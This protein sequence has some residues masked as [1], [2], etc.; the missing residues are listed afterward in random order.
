[1]GSRTSPLDIHAVLYNMPIHHLHTLL[2]LEMSL[3]ALSEVG[4]KILCSNLTP[5]SEVGAKFSCSNLT[6]LSEVG[7]KILCSNLTQMPIVSFL[8][9]EL[10][11]NPA[12]TLVPW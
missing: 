8:G 5:L 1:M 4:A 7:A 11:I 12:P 9:E 10:I 6:P 3:P 2:L